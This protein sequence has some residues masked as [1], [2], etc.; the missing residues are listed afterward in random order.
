MNIRKISA[1][2]FTLVEAMDTGI[3]EDYIIRVFPRLVE[4]N[5]HMYGLFIDK[6]L[7]VICGFTIFKNKYAML[8]RLRSDRNFRGRN[9]AT[10]LNEFLIEEALQ[11]DGVEWVGANT[12]EDNVPARKVLE[13]LGLKEQMA[14]H[15]AVTDDLDVML[16]GSPLWNEVTDIKEKQQFVDETLIKH[17]IIF[18]YQCYYPFP[19]SEELFRGE[20]DEWKFFVNQENSRFFIIKPD[21]KKHHYCH[22]VY[23]WDDLH[24]QEG[25]WETVKVEYEK[26]QA[27]LEDDVF[28]WIDLTKAQS[29]QLPPNHKFTLPPAWVLYSIQ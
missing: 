6:K 15:G 18:P 28:V 25:L 17:E 27:E 4:G 26:M 14:L 22:V 16:S 12:Q 7:A 21:Q 1:A 10:T 11:M 23:P 5:N 29:E 2:D 19:S 24:I 3:E 9:L 8:G 20:F 13:R